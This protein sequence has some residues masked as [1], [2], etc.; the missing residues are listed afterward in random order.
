MG[1]ELPDSGTLVARLDTDGNIATN[2][3]G[4]LSAEIY[5]S[6]GQLSSLILDQ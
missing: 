1:A 5:V 2:Q 6:K 3:A 4:D